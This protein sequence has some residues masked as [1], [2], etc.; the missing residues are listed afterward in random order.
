VNILQLS[1]GN[2]A[3]AMFLRKQFEVLGLFQGIGGTG[4]SISRTLFLADGSW[5]VTRYPADILRFLMLHSCGKS[6]TTKVV[7]FV[8]DGARMEIF[9]SNMN[10]YVQDVVLNFHNPR[11]WSGM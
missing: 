10:K 2:Q 11:L 9:A 4:V 6:S 7:R 5:K 8:Q 3:K 1:D